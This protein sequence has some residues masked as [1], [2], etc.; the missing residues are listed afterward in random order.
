MQSLSSP[1]KPKPWKALSQSCFNCCRVWY[2]LF[3][4]WSAKLKIISEVSGTRTGLTPSWEKQSLGLEITP[5]FFLSFPGSRHPASSHG[6]GGGLLPTQH[7]AALWSPSVKSHQ[8]ITHRQA[9]ARPNE[10]S[11]K[12]HTWF[13]LCFSEHLIHI[14]ATWSCTMVAR[15]AKCWII[16][17]REQESHQVDNKIDQH[18]GMNHFQK[19]MQFLIFR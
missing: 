16:L 17:C 5:P 14:Y 19:Q 12:C 4:C 8:N 9:E 6:T 7:K 11:D 3:T 1:I 15:N 18:K 2:R 13:L 10:S